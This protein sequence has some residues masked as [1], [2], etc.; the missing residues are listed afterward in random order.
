[1]DI[2]INKILK[3]ENNIFFKHNKKSN[4]DPVIKVLF[5]LNFNILKQNNLP[6]YKNKFIL[7]KEIMN[8]FIIKNSK[9]E[10][11]YYFNKI[12]RTYHSLN[13]FIFIYK[14][15]KSKIIVNTD[16]LLNEIKENDKNVICVYQ[17]NARYL[18]KI[19]DLIKIINMSLIHSQHFFADPLCIKNPYNNIPFGKNTL[20][21]IYY[22]LTEKTII[23]NNINHLELFLKFYSCQFN[24]TIFLNKYEYLLREKTIVNNIKNL[25]VDDSY[26][27]IM[28]MINEFNKNK[29]NKNKILIDNNFPKDKLVKIFIPYLNLYWNSKILLV[30]TLKYSAVCELEKKLIKF[31]KFNP[32]FGRMKVLYNKKICIDGKIRVFKIEDRANDSHI[33]FNEY[34]NDNFFK[35]HLAYTYNNIFDENEN[36]T[37]NMDLEFTTNELNNEN[38]ENNELNNELNNENNDDESYGYDEVD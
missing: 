36:E 28:E 22:F 20:Y 27:N 11:F 5:G 1:M 37:H 9:E 12:Q 31:Q 24:L 35:D 6:L 26:I 33:C 30:S 29:I 23:S 17:N 34:D 10:V 13:R 18:F 2:I 19:Y 16:M 7:L 8:N 14:F 32:L 4:I 21:Y 15:K 25:G 3:I 38:N